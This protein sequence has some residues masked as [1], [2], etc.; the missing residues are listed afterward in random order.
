MRQIRGKRNTGLFPYQSFQCGKLALKPRYAAAPMILF[1]YRQILLSNDFKPFAVS[2]VD[3]PFVCP[4]YSKGEK[5][6][7]RLVIIM[8]I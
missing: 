8:N 4:Y 2:D 7:Q 5:E 3:E 6:R 1:Y